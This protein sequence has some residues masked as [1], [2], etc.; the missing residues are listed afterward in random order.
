MSGQPV[1]R[2]LVALDESPHSRAALEEA[3]AL[4]AGL[5][6]ELMGIFVMDTDLLR[7]AGLPLG[8]ETGLTSARRR[9]LDPASMERA[10]RAQAEAARRAL[11]SIARQHR[12]RSSFLLSRGSVSGELI[13]AASRADIVAMGLIG[14]M[15]LAGRHLGS[16]TRRIRMQSRCSL[17][18]LAPGQRR[19][20][21]VLVLSTGSADSDRGLDLALELARRR[22]VDLV[23]LPCNDDPKVR[24]T[25]SARLVQS[26]VAVHLGKAPERFED[27]A[28]TISEQGGGI[29]VVGQDCPLIAGHDDQ[30]D[31]LG[32]PVLLAYAPESPPTAETAGAGGEA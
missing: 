15:G 25:V 12:L 13:E 17:L 11:D 19:G 7:L 9:V 21:R 10:L 27:L 24:E 32:C 5:Q 3:A 31:Q 23:V 16:T 30:L 14:H 22:G 29:L 4:A 20:S 2:I 26:G 6:A 18:L 28:V 8:R 1:R